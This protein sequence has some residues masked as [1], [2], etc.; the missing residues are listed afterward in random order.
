MENLIITSKNGKDV[1]TSLIVA[2]TFGKEHSKV[3]RDI[4]SLNCSP[5]FNVANFGVIYFQ[6]SMNRKQ[7]SYEITKDGF[8]FLV[9]GYTGAKAGEFKERFINEFNKR[10]ALLKNDDFIVQKALAILS[11][12]V[13]VIESEKERLQVKTE[14]QEQELKKVAPKMEYYEKV[15]QSESTYTTT[16]IAKELGYTAVDLNKILHDLGVQFK[17]HH[18][19]VLY[20]KYQDKGFTKTST[21][22]Y[23]DSKGISSTRM[24]TEW[25]ELGRKFIHDLIK[26]KVA[27]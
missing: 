14:I 6:D 5:E 4:E 18:T 19:W 25:T 7:K 3:C 24:Q 20:Q 2:E 9:M 21:F 16:L 26:E 8:S 13:K 11:E 17:Q 1:T 23:T 10:E 22:T 15:M 12:R 27:S